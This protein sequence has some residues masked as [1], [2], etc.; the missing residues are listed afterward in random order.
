MTPSVLTSKD[1]QKVKLHFI[2]YSRTLKNWGT[3]T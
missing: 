2:N 3:V 1:P